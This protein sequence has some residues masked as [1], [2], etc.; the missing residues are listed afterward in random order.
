MAEIKINVKSISGRKNKVKTVTFC[1][2]D[3]IRTIYDLIKN[4]VEYCV[5]LYNDRRE[6]S[7]LLAVLSP[8]VIG[9]MALS[10]KVSFGV[11]YSENNADPD[12]AIKNAAEAFSDGIVVIFA[13]DKKLESLDEPLDLSSVES[14]TF[15]KLSMLAGR[16]W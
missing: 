12:K 6:N 7:Q 16:M 8:D 13:D 2:D 10:G 3:E 5:K 15:I 9:D 4:T 11:N 14:F 1:C